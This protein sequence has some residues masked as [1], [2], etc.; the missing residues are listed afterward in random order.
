[1]DD[2]QKDSSSQT[3]VDNAT[4]KRSDYG[5]RCRDDEQM[6]HSMRPKAG[7]LKP[8]CADDAS[9]KEITLQGGAEVLW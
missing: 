2:P 9:R 3:A 6:G 5:Y 8:R 4:E 1:M 7:D